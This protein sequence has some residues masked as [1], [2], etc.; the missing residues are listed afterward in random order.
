MALQ[1]VSAVHYPFHWFVTYKA[2]LHGL[3]FMILERVAA[4]R[5]G[6]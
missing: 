2:T 6:G 4:D 5:E 1:S 3:I